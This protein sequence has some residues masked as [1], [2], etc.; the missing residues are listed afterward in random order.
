MVTMSTSERNAHSRIEDWAVGC[1]VRLLTTL[2]EVIEGTVFAFDPLSN[3]A[4]IS[5]NTSTTDTQDFRVLKASFIKRILSASLPELPIDRHL[6]YVDLMPPQS[7][8]EE[9]PEEPESEERETTKEIPTPEPEMEPVKKTQELPSAIEESP[10]VKEPITRVSTYASVSKGI[11]Q[12]VPTPAPAPAPVS[13]PAPK[14]P[15]GVKNPRITS[16]APYAQVAANAQQQNQNSETEGNKNAT[17]GAPGMVT[18]SL[19]PRL[20][21]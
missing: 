1:H 9:T 17:T 14:G 13:T 2:E 15:W 8:E 21:H 7:E 6:P 3:C 10:P 12:T 18:M 4:V 5:E 19:K 16:G 20:R 11:D